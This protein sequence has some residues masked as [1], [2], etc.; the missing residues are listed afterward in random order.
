ML[1]Q[2]KIQALNE[3]IPVT[4]GTQSLSVNLETDCVSHALWC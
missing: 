1:T 4:L 2:L 3:A